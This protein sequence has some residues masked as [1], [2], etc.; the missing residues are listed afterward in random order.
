MTDLWLVDDRLRIKDQPNGLLITV[1]AK[2]SPL[3][4][5]MLSG[6]GIL[7]VIVGAVYLIGAF[8]DSI[9]LLGA[10]F[11][12]I[13]WL[14]GPAFV[15][16]QLLWM[17]HG[18]ERLT[19]TDTHLIKTRTIKGFNSTTKYRIDQISNIRKTPSRYPND[20]SGKSKMERRNP[21]HH[22]HVAFDYRRKMNMFGE[23]LSDTEAERVIETLTRK[24]YGGGAV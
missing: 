20:F 16:L 9:S 11:G 14:I 1:D 17:F 10:I 13:L 4:F 6:V 23:G 21:R 8:F 3:S 7:W 15:G 12:I 18:V 2:F 24:I 19:L 22:G 5:F